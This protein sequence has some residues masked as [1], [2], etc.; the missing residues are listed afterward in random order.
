MIVCFSFPRHHRRIA[1]TICGKFAHIANIVRSFARCRFLQNWHDGNLNGICQHPF[2]IGSSRKVP[3]F[4]GVV[5]WN[6]RQ[7]LQKLFAIKKAGY[8]PPCWVSRGNRTH[9]RH[10]WQF[11]QKDT[12]KG[13]HQTTFLICF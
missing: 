9:N 7:R 1:R 10:T 11:F 5:R 12:K 8:F 2:A 6:T 13:G 4:P 3:R